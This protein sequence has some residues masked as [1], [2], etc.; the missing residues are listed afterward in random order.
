MCSS[1]FAPKVRQCHAHQRVKRLL[2][3]LRA[4]A[5]ERKAVSPA[6]SLTREQKAPSHHGVG[7]RGSGERRGRGQAG[8][9]V[10][11]EGDQDAAQGSAD[12]RGG[13]GGGWYSIV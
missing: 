4:R 12:T 3:S 13:Q 2:Y 1:S 10:G 6:L 7:S 9:R 5:S 11:R 8:V